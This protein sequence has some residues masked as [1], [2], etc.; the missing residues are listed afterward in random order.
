MTGYILAATALSAAITFGLRALPFIA[1]S[2]S[3]TMPHW[4]ERLGQQ[5]PAAIMAVLL[6]YCVKDAGTDWTGI[7]LPKLLALLATAASYK[8]RHNTLVSIAAGT[9]VYMILIQLL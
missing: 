9:A 2:G 8:L 6:V 4:M 1:F 3:R 5:L 7:G